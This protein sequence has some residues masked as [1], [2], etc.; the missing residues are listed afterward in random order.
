MRQCEVFLNERKVGML[1][2]NDRNDYEFVYDGA[3][4]SEQDAVPVSL[5]LP[6]QAEPY[7]SSVL[8]PF[9]F[10][11]LSEGDNRELQSH[12]LHINKDDDFGILLATA[13]Y[14]TIGAVTVK[15]VV[16]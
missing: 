6:L 7:R 10:N 2:E 1:T 9:F 12:L 4:L 15:P 14:D 5:T 16:S 8:F 3:Y 11:M 13:Q